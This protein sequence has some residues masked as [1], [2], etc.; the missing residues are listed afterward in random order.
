MANK[1]VNLGSPVIREAQTEGARRRPR[2]ETTECAAARPCRGGG[3]A[4]THCRCASVSW[5]WARAHA[6]PLARGAAEPVWKP[7]KP[8]GN[9]YPTAP[10]RR[11]GA[12]CGQWTGQDSAPTT[13]QVNLTGLVLSRS[14][15]CMIPWTCTSTATLV[16]VL[17]IEGAVASHTFT[18]R[19]KHH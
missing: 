12:P 14:H 4:H 11:E 18:Q 15:V 10:P 19:D 9:W 16:G 5:G 17:G 13:R 1:H 7:S 3:R 6:L 8:G 2:R